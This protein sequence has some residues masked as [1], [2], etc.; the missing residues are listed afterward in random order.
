M[1]DSQIFNIWS[2]ILSHLIR[3]KTEEQTVMILKNDHLDVCFSADIEWAVHVLCKAESDFRGLSA[4][5]RLVVHSLHPDQNV[6]VH[7]HTFICSC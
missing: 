4:R 2:Q 5:S 1:F 7:V 6:H 3:I